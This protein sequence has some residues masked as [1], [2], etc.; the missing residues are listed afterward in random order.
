MR[1]GL[2]IDRKNEQWGQK[3]EGRRQ[4]CWRQLNCR[5]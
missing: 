5:Y 4:L 3:A 1:Y 2:D